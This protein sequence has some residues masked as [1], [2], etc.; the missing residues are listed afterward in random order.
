[1][2]THARKITVTVDANAELD[3]SGLSSRARQVLGW[4][5]INTLEGLML[6]N[7]RHVLNARNVGHATV[8]EL[9]QLLL[10]HFQ[11]QEAE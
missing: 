8:Y 9:H 7:M 1:M 11:F 5:G 6:L 2:K 10:S 4:H 3:T